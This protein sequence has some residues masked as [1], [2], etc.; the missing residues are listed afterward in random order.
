MEVPLPQVRL[1]FPSYS[2]ME[3]RRKKRKKERWKEGGKKRQRE[4][5]Q[6][7]KETKEAGWCWKSPERLSRPTLH[8]EDEHTG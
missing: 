2:I 3:K 1:F 7:K 4:K 6:K 8:S 5:E